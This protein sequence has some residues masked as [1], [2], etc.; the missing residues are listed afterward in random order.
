VRKTNI[1]FVVF[2]WMSLC[3]SGNFNEIL[4]LV[5]ANM[6]WPMLKLHVL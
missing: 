2:F 4:Y 3:L 1:K 6:Y 5:F